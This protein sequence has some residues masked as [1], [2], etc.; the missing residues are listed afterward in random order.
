MEAALGHDVR[1][2]DGEFAGQFGQERLAAGAQFGGDR[3]AV[4]GPGG[5]ADEFEGRFLQRAG[6]EEAVDDLDGPQ[7]FQD[8]AA[9]SEGSHAQAGRG[10]LGQ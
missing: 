7:P 3:A 1:D 6:H 8:G 5:G 4:T 10:E 9:G 2:E